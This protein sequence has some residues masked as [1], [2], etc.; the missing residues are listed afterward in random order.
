MPNVSLDLASLHGNSNAFRYFLFTHVIPMKTIREKYGVNSCAN[1]VVSQA[2]PNNVPF[3]IFHAY[4]IL[5][6]I[7][8]P[9]AVNFKLLTIFDILGN[10]S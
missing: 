5:L 7:E 6:K 4:H 3:V 1:L 10:F 8:E 2:L 9:C